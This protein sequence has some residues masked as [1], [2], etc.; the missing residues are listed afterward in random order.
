MSSL[1]NEL[2][3]L[4]GEAKAAGT[5]VSEVKA[6]GRLIDFVTANLPA[7]VS[8]LRKREAEQAAA[9]RRFENPPS[10]PLER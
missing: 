6:S 2:E 8:A 5:F 3:K 1:A 4:A 10:L 9:K 7:I